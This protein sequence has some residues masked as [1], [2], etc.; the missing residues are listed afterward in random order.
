VSACGTCGGVG[1]V[2]SGGVNPDMSP[3]SVPC[4]ECKK[5][6]CAYCTEWRSDSSLEKWFPFSAETLKKQTQRITELQG[7]IASLKN[8]QLAAEEIAAWLEAGKYRTIQR[9]HDGSY[10]CRNEALN[11]QAEAESLE[12]LVSCEFWPKFRDCTERAP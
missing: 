1:V 11:I 7:I 2:D 9:R 6:T 12:S 8:R 5:C 3:I 10:R 4:P